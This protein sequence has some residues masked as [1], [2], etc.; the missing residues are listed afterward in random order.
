[1]SFLV[2]INPYSGKWIVLSSSFFQENTP[3]SFKTRK[4]AEKVKGNLNKKRRKN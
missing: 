1:M 4:Q 2:R 3:Y